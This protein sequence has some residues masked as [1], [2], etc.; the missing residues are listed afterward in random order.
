MMASS[1]ASRIRWDRLPI[2]PPVRSWR[3]AAQ[4]QQGAAAVRVQAKGVFQGRDE[5]LPGSSTE[6]ANRS[7]IAQVQVL[8]ASVGG[9][10]VVGGFDR[11]KIE[12]DALRLDHKMEWLKFGTH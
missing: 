8:P 5:R 9:G 11:G 1:A 10:W 12:R 4:A 7:R 3:V 2:M 6:L